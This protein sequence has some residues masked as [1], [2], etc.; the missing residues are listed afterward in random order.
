MQSKEDITDLIPYLGQSEMVKELRL[1]ALRNLKANS[2]SESEEK[3]CLR[4]CTKCGKWFTGSSESVIC[5]TC[6]TKP[7]S[8]RSLH[9][10]KMQEKKLLKLAKLNEE[11]RNE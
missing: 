3:K 6:E 2:P 11:L 1:I 4:K 7:P 5:R 10:A 9:R 8:A